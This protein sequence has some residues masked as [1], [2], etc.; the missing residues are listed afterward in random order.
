MDWMALSSPVFIGSREDAIIIEDRVCV[1]RL[2]RERREQ[3]KEFAELVLNGDREKRKETRSQCVRQLIDWLIG[4]FVAVAVA[5]WLLVVTVVVAAS[6]RCWCRHACVRVLLLGV[7]FACLQRRPPSDQGTRVCAAA[8]TPAKTPIIV[9]VGE[10]AACGVRLRL[11]SDPTADADRASD[12][13]SA[14]PSFQVYL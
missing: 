1:W 3:E 13:T 14:R 11:L 7:R 12:M 10:A 4:W 2:A 9:A 5:C 8:W 6:A